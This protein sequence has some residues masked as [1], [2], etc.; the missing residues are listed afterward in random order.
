M[1]REIRFRGKTVNGDEWIYGETISHGTIKRK[2][3][4]WFM[5]VSENKWKG[6][7]DG[8]L[9]QFTGFCDVNDEEIYEGDIVQYTDPVTRKTHRF[10]VVFDLGCFGLRNENVTKQTTPM[11]SHIM[12]KWAVVGNMY[13][14]PELLK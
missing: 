14:S 13:D 6:L 3:H 8:S 11:S 9:G 2:A 7:Q 1:E 5:E 4:K 12:T 10:Q